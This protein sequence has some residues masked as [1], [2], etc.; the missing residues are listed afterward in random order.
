[1]ISM[2]K[3][4]ILIDQS[5]VIQINEEMYYSDELE[6]VLSELTGKWC[7]HFSQETEDFFSYKRNSLKQD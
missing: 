5:G 1:M 2:K 7:T 3:G 4:Y 6:T